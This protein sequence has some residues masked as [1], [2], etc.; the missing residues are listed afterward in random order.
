MSTIKKNNPYGLKAHSHLNGGGMAS[1][2]MSQYHISDQSASLNKG[3]PIVFDQ[4]SATFDSDVMSKSVCLY[5]HTV[6]MQ[7]GGTATAIEGADGNANSKVILGVFQGCEFT[8]VEGR[9]E[10]KDYWVEGTQVREGTKPIAYVNTDPDVVWSIQLSSWTG[11]VVGTTHQFAIL[12]SLQP[13]ADNWPNTGGGAND[14][15]L[16]S[17]AV[18][19][20]NIE[21]L[22]GRNTIGCLLYTSPSPRD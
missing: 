21:L 8:N 19:G 20:T 10:Y 1:K 22:T 4:R 9:R 6:T 11:A 15:A 2:V 14:A 17:S 13:Q 3:D 16:A 5:G 18:V 7:E 12:P